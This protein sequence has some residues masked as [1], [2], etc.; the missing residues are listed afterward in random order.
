MFSLWEFSSL[1]FCFVTHNMN[2]K[3]EQK[4][5][6]SEKKS[7]CTPDYVIKSVENR[8]GEPTILIYL[9]LV[10]LHLQYSNSVLGSLR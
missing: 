3:I 5:A 6:L 7:N 2:M 8:S 1:S 10:R 4:F 9:T